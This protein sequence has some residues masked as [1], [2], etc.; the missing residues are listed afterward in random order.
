M[1]K[2]D[3]LDNWLIMKLNGPW[4]SGVW[5]VHRLGGHIE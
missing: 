5:F 4:F 1:G 2:Q 3:R